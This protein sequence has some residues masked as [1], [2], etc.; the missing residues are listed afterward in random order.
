MSRIILQQIQLVNWYGF[1]DAVIP[2]SPDLTLI[3][4]E[5]ECGKSTILDAIKY[6]YTGDTQFNRSGGSYQTGM[7]KRNLVSYTRCLVDASAG[8]Y[9]RSA[10]H[11]PTVITH[12][13][14]T[15]LDALHGDRFVLGVVIE[16][17]P[18]DIRGTNWYAFDLSAKEQM[19]FLYEADGV[20]RVYDAK[21]LHEQYQVK[22][23]NKTDGVA[24]F[25]QRLGLKL[26]YREV[27][28]YQ[29]KLRNIMAYNPAA[30]IQDFIKESVLEVHDIK[31]DK[32][33]DA[34]KNIESITLNLEQIRAEL[35]DLDAI[36][37]AFDEQDRIARRLQ[38]DDVKRIYK[39]LLKKQREAE[40][41]KEFIV[42]SEAEQEGIAAE[43]ERQGEELKRLANTIDELR[44][45]LKEMDVYQ[46]IQK[47][48][49]AI[50][51]HR[52]LLETFAKQKQELEDF[53]EKSRAAL[54]RMQKEQEEVTV[55]MAVSLC[56]TAVTGTEK[57][58]YIERLKE[59]FRAYR[60]NLI[61][62][63]SGLK[64]EQ[65]EREKEI[66]AVQE[67]IALCEKNK[68]D[69]SY[70]KDQMALIREINRALTD[71]GRKG[72]ARLACEYV[73]QFMDES[74]R[75]ATEAFLGRHRYAI[76][77][78]PEDFAIA[79]AVMD[80]SSFRYVE[81]VNTGRLMSYQAEIYEDALYH[82]L[83]IHNDTA[84]RYFA[85]L[86]GRIH[87]VEKDA[88]P[89][90]DNA[91]SREG[92]LS[93]NMAVTYVDFRKIRSY[94]LGGEAV[95]LN[96][97]RARKKMKS[98]EAEETE[99]L[100]V[101]KLTEI[102]K[103][104]FTEILEMFH[105]FSFDAH[106]QE[107]ETVRSLQEEERHLRELMDAQKCNAEFMTLN[108]QL[109]EA[110]GRESVLKRK[111]GELE[112]QKERLKIQA[113]EKKKVLAEMEKEIA[114]HRQELEEEQHR[115]SSVAK[116]AM[117]ELDAFLA[118][119]KNGHDVMKPDS[120]RRREGDL[121]N[122]QTELRAKQ[123]NYNNRKS[124]TEKLPEGLEHEA[125]YQARRGKIWIDDLQSV[126]ERLREQTVKYQKIFKHEFVLNIYETAKEARQQIGEI[127]RELRKLGFSTRYQFDVKLLD[128]TGDFAK[129]LRYAEYLEKTNDAGDGQV[130]FTELLGM[131]R[132][133]AERREQEI[134]AIINRMLD[135]NDPGELQKYAD[136]RNYMSYEIII[137]N[138]TIHGGKLSKQV[139][140][141]S[142]AGTQIPYTL[143][144]AAF[145]S[146][147]YN[148]REN[149]IRLFFIDEPFEKMSDHNIQLMLDFFK[150][151]KFQVLFCAPPNKLESI[152]SECGVI[153][154]VLKRSNDNMLIGQVRFH[155]SI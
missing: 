24:L 138:D 97:E 92:K 18:S 69:Y 14:L 74:W 11:Y 75:D 20:K 128:N 59:A 21:E 28:K 32:L 13:A 134:Q 67:M 72:V 49:E 139:G 145:L 68:P 143:I 107:E 12:I 89:E 111:K 63:L 19:S 46:A 98:L 151:Q 102:T 142:G 33:K 38:V 112:S 4:G 115:A 121:A 150:A 126:Q 137:D 40:E 135:K 82:Q 56:S 88:V 140:Y 91:I 78:E 22:L 146:M 9:A 58:L 99:N 131:D 129:I 83:V 148:A 101:Q 37:K 3:S 133:E 60:D 153:I 23:F 6:A 10:E 65:A 110:T 117:G 109:S 47:A 122:T 149:V 84:A 17:G 103:Q 44:R 94:A 113:E 96:L 54:S 152:G 53:E 16:T 36:L 25:M 7:G 55:P 34:K 66:L 64:N 100:R 77:V 141:N 125:A 116:Q 147:L 132:E 108:S 93:R 136:Y 104:Q 76:I 81:L 85:Y 45:A 30:K 105:P 41:A 57:A 86:L 35:A 70:V 5:N 119:E 124:E 155:D 144:L 15:Y 43:A 8:V 90:F 95:R 118:G 130:S 27:G 120:R 114:A 26:P 106:R 2:V 80:R 62:R 42:R 127:N 73:A 79:N 50:V 71:S 29:R 31:F 51:K 1:T 52:V 123:Q 61:I 87:A 48:E 39:V 154:P